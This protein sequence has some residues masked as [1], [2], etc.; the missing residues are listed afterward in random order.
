MLAPGGRLFLLDVA[1]TRELR[2]EARSDPELWAAC[3][4]GALTETELASA[5]RSAGF[6]ACRLMDRFD[7][8]ANTR[9]REKVSFDL[10][11]HGVNFFARKPS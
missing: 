8:Y 6:E 1:V 9:A 3:I 7:C 5:A 4:G 11:P 2:L 10:A